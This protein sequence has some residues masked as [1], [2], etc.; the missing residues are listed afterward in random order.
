VRIVACVVALAFVL[1]SVQSV[2]GPPIPIGQF[3]LT[4]AERAHALRFRSRSGVE[5]GGVLLGRGPVGIVLV[6]ESPG[7]VCQWLFYARVLERRGYAVLLIDLNGFGSSPPA[8]G[9]PA[10]PHWDRDVAAAAAVLRAHGVKKVVLIGASLGGTCVIAA[11]SEIRPP[12]AAVVDLSGPT[13]SSGI[14][15]LAAARHLRVPALYEVSGDDEFVDAVR[16]VYRAT[17]ARLRKLVVVRSGGGHGVG[18]LM[19]DLQPHASENRA[20]IEAFIRANT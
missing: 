5:I 6:H 8:P 20:A 12:V 14:E 16:Q 13:E 19:T 9:S 4:K 3:C 11:A 17:P 1:G 2:A 7:D 18:L 10:R 15:A